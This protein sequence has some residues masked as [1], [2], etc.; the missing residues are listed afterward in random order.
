MKEIRRATR[1]QFSAEEKIRIVLSGLRGEDSIA[2]LCRRVVVRCCWRVC[3]GLSIR[4]DAQGFRRPCPDRCRSQIL[5]VKLRVFFCK[6][7]CDARPLHDPAEY[8]T[9]FRP[10]RPSSHDL[11]RGAIERAARGTHHIRRYGAAPAL[12]PLPEPPG[13]FG[14]ELATIWQNTFAAAAPGSLTA[15]D[16][17]NLAAYCIAVMI[18]RRPGQRV[19]PEAFA[20]PQP[21]RRLARGWAHAWTALDEYHTAGDPALLPP[22][23][24]LD[25]RRGL[26]AGR[27][28]DNSSFLYPGH[29]VCRLCEADGLSECRF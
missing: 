20:E 29:I 10:H 15:L 24:S 18:H 28:P 7:R 5:C 12:P 16:Y 21:G 3:T 6:N 2:E 26:K 23:L 19:T 27:G 11:G 1:L 8:E 4:G 14:A 17:D 22:R 9:Q 25:A 13:W